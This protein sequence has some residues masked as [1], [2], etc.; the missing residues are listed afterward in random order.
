MRKTLD[1]LG[2][3]LFWAVALP[4]FIGLALLIG[5]GWLVNSVVMWVCDA[6]ERWENRGLTPEQIAKQEWE[7]R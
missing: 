7:M 1:F 3:L 2:F 6:A 4:A 5:A